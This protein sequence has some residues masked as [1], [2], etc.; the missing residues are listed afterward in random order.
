MRDATTCSVDE[1][2]RSVRSRGLCG[3]H[4]KRE[5][6]AQRLP[7]RPAK[8][9]CCTMSD[10]AAPIY[11]RGW[12]DDHY[13]YHYEFE[14]RV[15][16]AARRGAKPRPIH[17]PTFRTCPRCEGQFPL[18]YYPPSKRA[19]S[20]WVCHP[21]AMNR[22]RADRDADP[23]RFAK[24]ARKAYRVNDARY[25]NHGITAEMAHALL[26]KQGGRCPVCTDQIDLADTYQTAIDHDHA[27]CPGRLSCGKCVRAILC[28][29][30][31][32]L[33]GLIEIRPERVTR[34][35]QFTGV[36]F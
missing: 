23:D 8:P 7:K 3:P 10:C 20:M 9:T 12:C 34:A 36:L 30:C 35:L 15:T 2:D 28:R 11:T 1:C 16:K 26:D 27:C 18:T 29:S 32:I 24:Y 21:C 4:Y 14:R 25:K 33:V 17:D 31:N 13:E 5:W 6:R 19:Q 22:L